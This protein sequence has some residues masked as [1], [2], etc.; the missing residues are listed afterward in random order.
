MRKIIQ[1]HI[2]DS[3]TVKEKLLHNTEIISKIEFIT[4]EIVEAYKNGKKL[5]IAGNGGSAADAQHMAAELVGKFYLDRKGLFTIALN[6][7]TSILTSIANDYNFN[8]IFSR[9]IQAYGEKGDVFI[10]ISTSGN[11]ANIIEALKEANKKGILTVGVVGGKAC[12]IDEIS[13]YCIKI[14]S[15]KTPIIQ[16][17]HIMIGHIICELIEK[18]LFTKEK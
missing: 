3:I 9:Q 1:E 7:N 17:A 12:K 14:P 5:L 13:N 11:S 8:K 15:D 18:K 4:G 10:G 2:K 6:T 16:E